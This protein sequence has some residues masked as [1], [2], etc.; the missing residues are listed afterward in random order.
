MTLVFDYSVQ[1][2]IGDEQ[3]YSDSLC[4]LEF[5]Q[6]IYWEAGMNAPYAQISNPAKLRITLNN[7]D[8]RYNLDSVLYGKPL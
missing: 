2:D 3:A 5:V 6:Q 1:L 8:G 7:V 4:E